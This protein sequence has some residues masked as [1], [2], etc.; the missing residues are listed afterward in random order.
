MATTMKRFMLTIPS[1]IEDEVEELKK[2]IFYN[3]PYS[4][5]YRQLIQLGL[6]SLKPTVSA[7]VTSLGV[8]CNSPAIN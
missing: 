4:E 3:K 6:D 5:V 7:Q 1:D 8:S 2:G